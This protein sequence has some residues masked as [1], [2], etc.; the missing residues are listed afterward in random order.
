MTEETVL[1]FVTASEFGR[2]VSD[3]QAIDALEEAL[4]SQDAT[5]RTPLRT[6]TDLPAG[7]LLYMPSQVGELVGIKLASV[8]PDNPTRGLPRIQGL[9]VLLDAATFQPRALLDAGGL[10]VVRTSAVSGLAV[11][12][13]AD[14]AARHMVVFGSGP[15]AEGHVAAVRAVRPIDKVTVVGR[16]PE[17]TAQLVQR[18]NA[19]GLAAAVGSPQDVADADIV[20]CCTTARTPLFDSA[21]LQDGVT[22]VAVG[23]HEPSAR[24]VDSALVQRAFVVVET[25]TSAFAEAGDIIMARTEGLSRDEEV[26]AELADIV[27]KPPMHS[28]QLRLFKGVGEAW[29]DVVVAGL[30]AR[31]LGIPLTL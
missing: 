30:A 29:A 18:L 6:M 10:T 1:P 14:P 2:V 23:S 28:T 20:A 26:D 3:L 12:H 7:Q 8:A 25:R 11:R 16:S 15:Q 9:V 5:E 31:T 27:R 19:S 4:R 13:L 17:P 22:V 24:E 21:L